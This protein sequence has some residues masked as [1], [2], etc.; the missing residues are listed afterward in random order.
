[1][2]IHPP[3]KPIE[4][5]KDFLVHLSII[6]I[7]I[8]IALGL[9]QAVEGW[10]HYEVGEEARKNIV[11]EIRDNQRELEGDRALVAK[12]EENLRHALE[13]IRQYLAHQKPKDATVAIAVNGADLNSTSWNTALATGAL[14]YMGYADAK[15]FTR[16]YHL[17]EMLERVQD[18]EFRIGA[19]ALMPMKYSPKGPESMTDEQLRATER[20]ILAALAGVTQWAQLA[21]QLSDEYARVLKAS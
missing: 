6:T 19:Q 9:E 8:L 10:H 7:G 5:M 3:T 16:A 1:M 18:E 21:A 20:D 17:Q 11:S 4:S 2:E 13:V 14:G 15:K 12:N